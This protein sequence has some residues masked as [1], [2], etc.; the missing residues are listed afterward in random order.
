M[1]SA[2]LFLIPNLNAQ[3]II[4]QGKVKANFG[5]DADVKADSTKFIFPISDRPL[6][7]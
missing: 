3:I 1:V 4:E 6:T 2:F 7:S 5:I